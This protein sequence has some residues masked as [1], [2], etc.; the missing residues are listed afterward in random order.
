MKSKVDLI[1]KQ[2]EI[3]SSKEINSTETQQQLEQSQ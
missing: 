2:E 1:Q 3:L